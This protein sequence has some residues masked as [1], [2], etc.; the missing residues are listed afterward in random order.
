M[1]SP[2]AI[3]TGA[4]SAIGLA[5]SKYLLEHKWNVV[6]ADIQPPKEKFD[7]SLFIS[8]DVTSWD[9]Q[10][11]MFKQAYEWKGRLDFIHLNAG[12]DD[13]DD[14]FDSISSHPAKPPRE[15]NLK[16]F[17]VNLFGPYY[18]L[19]L[20]AHYLSLD[21]TAAGK[22]K[23]GGKVVITASAAGIYPIPSVPQYGST[24]HGII[25]LVRSAAPKAGLVNIRVNALCPALIK[26]KIAPQEVFDS[27]QEASFTPM[28]TIMRCISELAVLEQVGDED[29]VEQGPN[30]AAVEGN[31]QELI[32]HSPPERPAISTYASDEGLKVWSRVYKERNTKFA[33]SD[34]K[35]GE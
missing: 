14:I 13:R 33:E 15:P 7:N 30:G 27:F 29:W 6:M 10:A 11:A 17:H 23:P 26:T 21:S 31:Q 8:C 18:G 34:W 25:G 24:K 32:W 28:S 4:S 12:I 2:V 1:A 3:V 22:S 5:T 9:S 20:A 19:K 16:T 35:K